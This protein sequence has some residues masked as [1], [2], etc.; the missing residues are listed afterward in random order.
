MIPRLVCKRYDS[1]KCCNSLYGKRG[2][3]SRAEVPSRRGVPPIHADTVVIEVVQWILVII[4]LMAM[5]H[6]N[7]VSDKR[8]WNRF[9]SLCRADD[10]HYVT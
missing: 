4:T 1:L 9:I 5:R 6:T 2:K 3:K 8:E 10:Q 7:V